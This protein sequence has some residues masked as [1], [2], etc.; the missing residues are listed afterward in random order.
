MGGSWLGFMVGF[1]IVHFT[2]QLLR[3]GFSK[4]S[5]VNQWLT[6]I[7]PIHSL[8]L[9]VRFVCVVL[10]VGVDVAIDIYSGGFNLGR[11]FNLY[12]IP[13]FS[14]S[15]LFGAGIT[16][17]AW[18]FCLLAVYYLDIPPRYSFAI[19][20]VQDI[21][22]LLVF[23]ILCGIVFVIPKLLFASAELANAKQEWS[24]RG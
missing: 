17:W 3:S 11:E 21:L 20:S 9:P 14:S 22:H 16:V 2:F 7:R 5:F 19:A 6:K 18:L 12:L 15:L 13:I 10:L 4:N 24:T 8:P 23:F 1:I